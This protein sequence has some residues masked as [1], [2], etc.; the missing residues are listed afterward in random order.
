MEATGIRCVPQVAR[1]SKHPH[2]PAPAD[3]MD[4]TDLRDSLQEY[5]LSDPYTV[6]PPSIPCPT[7]LKEAKHFVSVSEKNCQ[8]LYDE[9]AACRNQQVHATMDIVLHRCTVQIRE[10]RKQ[11]LTIQLNINK[12][13]TEKSEG[14]RMANSLTPGEIKM[15]LKEQDS[16]LAML[17][18]AFSKATLATEILRKKIVQRQHI[19]KL[20][21][22]LAMDDLN[23]QATLA[24]IRIKYPISNENWLTTITLGVW[25]SKETFLASSPKQTLA[26]DEVGSALL[27]K[28]T[29]GWWNRLTG[30]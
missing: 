4:H 10:I 5:N 13:A 18:E 19:L 3:Q 16:R 28:Y 2:M 8:D 9:L 1:P 22:S 20:A 30:T 21:Q 23:H 15:A 24:Q 26:K 17:E 7:P 12:L 14:E 11:R 27:D 6:P 25:A 29:M